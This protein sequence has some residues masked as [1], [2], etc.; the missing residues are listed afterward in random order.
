MAFGVI[1]VERHGELG[2]AVLHTVMAVFF[3][4]NFLLSGIASEGPCLRRPAI[5]M[6]SITQLYLTGI[7]TLGMIPIA[8]VSA[9][10][11]GLGWLVP[12]YGLWELAVAALL[13]GKRTLLQQRSEEQLERE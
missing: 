11:A 10:S 9:T 6:R 8:S 2:T 3:T 5:R 1:W 12:A 4:F 7:G 13:L